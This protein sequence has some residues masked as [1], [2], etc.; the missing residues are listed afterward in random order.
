[1]EVSFAITCDDERTILSSQMD[2]AAWVS[3]EKLIECLNRDSSS[4]ISGQM[5]GWKSKGYLANAR[6][7]YGWRRAI[8]RIKEEDLLA[9]LRRCGEESAS[10]ARSK[11]IMLKIA[12][13]ITNALIHSYQG[14]HKISFIQIEDVDPSGRAT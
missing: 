2:K 4:S 3:I 7:A 14:R 6:D 12:G 5:F 11:P 8:E 9:A 10:L 13:E 1:M